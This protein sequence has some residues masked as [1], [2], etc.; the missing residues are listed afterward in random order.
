M[1]YVQNIIGQ[2]VSIH[3]LL[4]SSICSQINWLQTIQNALNLAVTKSPTR[5]R[6]YSPL[7][8]NLLNTCSRNEFMNHLSMNNNLNLLFASSGWRYNNQNHFVFLYSLFLP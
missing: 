6:R 1:Y 8:S 5:L 7:L 2:Y 3:L 4:D